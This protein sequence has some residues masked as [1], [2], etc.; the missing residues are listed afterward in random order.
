[1]NQARSRAGVGTGAIIRNALY[2]G[3]ELRNSLFSADSLKEIV[4]PPSQHIE[5]LFDQ[6]GNRGDLNR[7]L[8][9]DVKS[10]LCDNILTKVD[11][12]S[13]AV[14][15]EARVPYPDPDLVS[16]AFQVPE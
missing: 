9:V 7:S 6:A 1:M 5:R 4:S 11:R 14:S 8:Y 16:L 3:E 13:M 2:V 15:L 12:M 10:Y